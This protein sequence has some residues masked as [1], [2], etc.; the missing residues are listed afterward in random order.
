MVPNNTLGFQGAARSSKQ[1]SVSI[2]IKVPG[3]GT[4]AGTATAYT[5]SI[6]FKA[7]RKKQR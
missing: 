2:P 6:T 1:G 3:P 5:R 4:L 7:S